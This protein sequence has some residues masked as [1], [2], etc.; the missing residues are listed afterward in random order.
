MD[1]VDCILD[2]LAAESEK[3]STT[4]QEI[5]RYE[6]VCI[7]TTSRMAVNIPG[8]HT[9]ELATLSGDGA[10]DTFYG[11]CHLNRSLAIDDLIG[12]LDFHPL[13]IDL[14]ARAVLKH[15]WDEPRLL[16]EWKS[17]QT[18]VLELDSRQSLE[19]VIESV[20]DSPTIQDLGLV[21]YKIME[22]ISAFPGGGGRGNGGEDV[23][24]DRRCS[25]GSRRALQVLF[26]G[27]P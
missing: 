21:A 13:S 7:L 4:I 11:L 16:Q 3:I 2:P 27:S 26:V 18:D 10:R 25:G 6:N 22:A 12:D 9:I 23:S 17:D 8:L 14:L 15:D 1:A 5:N 19:A 24:R 20:L